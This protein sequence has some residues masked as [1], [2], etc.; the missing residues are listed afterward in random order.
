M[1]R[2]NEDLVWEEAWYHK[3][4]PGSVHSLH[5]SDA[6]ENLYDKLYYE[7]NSRLV[8]RYAD[9]DAVFTICRIYGADE[10]YVRWLLEGRVGI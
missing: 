10:G 6:V 2:K 3:A 8:N 1:S 5:L 7:G 9:E 4:H